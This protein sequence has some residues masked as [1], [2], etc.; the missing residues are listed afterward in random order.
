MLFYYNYRMISYDTLGKKTCDSQ[1]KLPNQQQK[2]KSKISKEYNNTKIKRIKLFHFKNA[3]LF[4]LKFST[5]NM[6]TKLRLIELFQKSRL[7]PNIELPPELSLPTDM[8]S[9]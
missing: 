3:V 9:P 2:N 6:M 8:P 7:F 5:L 4:C 1:L